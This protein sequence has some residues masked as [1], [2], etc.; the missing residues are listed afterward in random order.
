[1]LQYV[2][3]GGTNKNY[4]ALRGQGLQSV[5]TFQACFIEPCPRVELLSVRGPLPPMGPAV[6]RLRNLERILAARHSPAVHS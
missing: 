5:S 4:W 2:K 6:I 3:A 1:M